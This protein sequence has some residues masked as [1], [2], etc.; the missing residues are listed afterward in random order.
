MD[1]CVTV[2]RIA[3]TPMVVAPELQAIMERN[4]ELARCIADPGTYYRSDQLPE[5]MGRFANCPTGRYMLVL[6]L[7]GII[8]FEKIQSATNRKRIR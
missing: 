5:L 4:R 2:T 8:S 3:V 7:P 6:C 1:A